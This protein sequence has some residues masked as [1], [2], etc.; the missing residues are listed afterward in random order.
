MAMTSKPRLSRHNGW[1][2]DRPR[3]KRAR[4]SR[5]KLKEV[6]VVFFDWH[7]VIHYEFVPRGQTVNK[8]FYVA[9][10]KRL[11]EAVRRKRPQLWT[12][13]SWVLHHDNALTR[14]SLYAISGEKRKDRCTPATLLSRFGSSGLSSVS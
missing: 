1:G 2:K 8:E 5:S 6:M 4:M 10:L 7:G 9:V 11:R 12:N 14:R 13:Q 3:P